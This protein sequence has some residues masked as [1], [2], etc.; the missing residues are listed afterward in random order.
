MAF[1]DLATFEK[2]EILDYAQAM[3][4]RPMMYA[5]SPG[6]L[7][8][9]VLLLLGL[10]WDRDGGDDLIRNR[11]HEYH[12]KAFKLGNIPSIAYLLATQDLPPGT[13]D[14]E[15]FKKVADFLRGFI[16]HL[17]ENP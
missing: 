3:L 5:Q 6:S 2:Q 4:T 9:Q 10:M 7:E 17:E 14:D 15:C 8:D 1:L 11:W 13:L 12:Y 16:K